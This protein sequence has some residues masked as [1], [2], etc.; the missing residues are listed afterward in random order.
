M[1]YAYSIVHQ[2]C[3]SILSTCFNKIKAIKQCTISS[4][5]L[6]YSGIIYVLNSYFSDSLYYLCIEFILYVLL[7]IVSWSY[8]WSVL[9]H[10]YRIEIFCG[11]FVDLLGRNTIQN[12]F[13]KIGNKNKIRF[14]LFYMDVKTS[15]ASLCSQLSFWIQRWGQ[16]IS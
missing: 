16:K 5:R 10:I 6:Y 12:E 11:D 4:G 7:S 13:R 9:H 8:L 1:Q 2:K 3:N 15:K 14:L